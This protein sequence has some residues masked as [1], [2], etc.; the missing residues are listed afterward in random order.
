MA[1]L[2]RTLKASNLIKPYSGPVKDCHSVL[3]S[4]G[5]PGVDVPVESLDLAE[6]DCLAHRLDQMASSTQNEA[7]AKAIT[8]EFENIVLLVRR[9][10]KEAGGAFTGILGTGANLTALWLRPKDVGGVILRGAAAAGALGL[11]A[12]GGGAIFTWLQTFVANTAQN[13]IPAQTMIQYAGIL[14]IGLLDNVD[15]PKINA[16]QITISG[17][18]AQAETFMFD[19]RR[20]N[21]DS[22]NVSFVR[23]EKPYFIGPLVNQLLAVM[24]GPAGDSRPELVSILIC[25]AQDVVI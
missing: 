9:V 22:Y 5:K 18:P 25:R 3:I 24:P 20:Q 14:H 17:I 10:K 16:A 4:P 13:M 2:Y 6:V 23:F 8:E 15:V 1:E 12:G 19:N 7:I 11:Y 21:G